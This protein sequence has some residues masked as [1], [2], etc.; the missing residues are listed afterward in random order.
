MGEIV[1][2]ILGE[3]I[4]SYETQIDGNIRIGFVE[5][6]IVID[7]LIRATIFNKTIFS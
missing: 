1:K 3:L 2:D 6:G 4:E 5:N 7:P